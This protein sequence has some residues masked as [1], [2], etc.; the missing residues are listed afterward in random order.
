[1][2]RKPLPM[3]V[4]TGTLSQVGWP[5]FILAFSLMAVLLCSDLVISKDR[6]KNISKRSATNVV[7]LAQNLISPVFE[8]SDMVLQRAIRDYG[9]AMRGD[10]NVDVLAVNVNLSALVSGLSEAQPDSLRLANQDGQVVFD[11]GSKEKLSDISIADKPYFSTHKTVNNPGFLISEPVISR[12]TGKWVIPISRRLNDANGQFSG[13][14]ILSV[15]ADQII[16]LFDKLA[17]GENSSVSILAMDGSL[18]ARSPAVS[19]DVEQEFQVDG[20]F[21]YISKKINSGDIVAKSLIN[22]TVNDVY[23]LK[24]QDMPLIVTVSVSINEYLNEWYRK[25]AYYAICLTFMAF[26]IGWFRYILVKSKQ[27]DRQTKELQAQVKSVEDSE[28]FKNK[29]LHVFSKSIRKTLNEILGVVKDL[30]KSKEVSVGQVVVDQFYSKTKET[31]NVID[32]LEIV[33]KLHAGDVKPSSSEFN[34]EPAVASVFMDLTPMAKLKEIH[35]MHSKSEMDVQ[36][37]NSDEALVRSVLSLVLRNAIQLCETDTIRM[38]TVVNSSNLEIQ[39]RFVGVSLPEYVTKNMFSALDQSEDSVNLSPD[40]INLSLSA[41][42]KIM[43][44]LNGKIL[45]E[46]SLSGENEFLLSIPIG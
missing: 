40:R 5:I 9:Q 12:L 33:L 19:V 20:V 14:A 37:V 15:R 38:K 27:E 41:A 44:L 34:L 30:R 2:I 17:L 11:A 4:T 3:R 39:I 31:L 36:I 22:G 21:E 45:A 23:F 24:L 7:S 29:L 42:G 43:S 8:K 18:L 25:C 1:M 10:P 6:D 35:L 26:I 46:S 13:V 28:I 16:D 32:D